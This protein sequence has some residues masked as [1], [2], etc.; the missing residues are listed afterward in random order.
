[1]GNLSLPTK[2]TVVK[3]EDSHDMTERAVE[4]IHRQPPVRQEEVKAAVMATKK[5][6]FDLPTDKYRFIKLYC[7]DKDIT[8][9]EYFMDLIEADYKKR[10][11]K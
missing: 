2:P 9:R 1:M 5:I 10:G 4:T 11:N 6:S 8:M 3:T 7:L